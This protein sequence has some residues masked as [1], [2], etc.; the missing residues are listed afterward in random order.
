[1]ARKFEEKKQHF[2]DEVCVKELADMATE[3]CET[4]LKDFNQQLLDQVDQIKLVSNLGRAIL[5]FRLET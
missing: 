4:K 2:G 1:M 5:V 3:V